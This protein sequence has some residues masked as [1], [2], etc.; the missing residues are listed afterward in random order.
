VKKLKEKYDLVSVQMIDFFP[1]T[2]HIEA[3]V[4][5]QLR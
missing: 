3:V 5:L 2:F 4:F 1:N